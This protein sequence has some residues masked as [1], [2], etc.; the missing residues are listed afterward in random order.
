MID[1]VCSSTSW[2]NESVAL[3]RRPI[4]MVRGRVNPTTVSSWTIASGD[5]STDFEERGFTETP[6]S[7]PTMAY[8]YVTASPC[9]TISAS[10]LDAEVFA[11]FDRFLCDLELGVA[12]NAS[13]SIAKIA[14]NIQP[15]QDQHLKSQKEIELWATRLAQAIKDLSD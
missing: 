1:V 9:W 6:S 12:V 15:S 4:S 5:F 13:D 2:S 3:N 8:L 14:S 11:K 7:V 10:E